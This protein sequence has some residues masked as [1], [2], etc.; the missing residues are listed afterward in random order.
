M[1]KSLECVPIS[2]CCTSRQI[3]AGFANSNYAGTKQLDVPAQK[4]ARAGN[5]SKASQTICSTLKPALKSDTLDKLKAK[6]P[7]D[8]TGFDSRHWPTA[9]KMDALRRDDDWQ[10][11]EAESFSVKKIRQHFAAARH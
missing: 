5:L 9:E 1:E 3:G 2:R 8:S 6:P 11:T 7:Q 10:N 4:H